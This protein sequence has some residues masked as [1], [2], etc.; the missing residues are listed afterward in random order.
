[1]R[2]DIYREICNIS[3][4]KL[5]NFSQKLIPDAKI[6]GAKVPDVRAMAKK[7]ADNGTEILKDLKYEYFEETI[8]AGFIICFLKTDIKTKLKYLENYIVNIKNWAECDC[9]ASAFKFKKSESEI[10]WNFI[11][12][13]FSKD[14]EFEKRFAVIMSLSHFLDEKHIDE[15][16]EIAQNIKSGQ[17]Y[18][19]MGIGWLI[20]VCFI[21][22]REKTET[23]LENGKLSNEIL[24]ITLSK[25]KQSKRVSKEDKERA[26][27]L[28]KRRT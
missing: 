19:D 17:F 20:L 12:P 8:F 27:R 7:Y 10:V 9:V 21:K 5:K 18:T 15:I 3:T 22:F 6:I 14:G 16:L 26:E 23:V 25:I 24:K 28:I 1:M 13:Y 2:D 4:E 11:K